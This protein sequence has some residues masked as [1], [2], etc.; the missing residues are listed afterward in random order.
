MS[1]I[2]KP[3]RHLSYKIRL[4]IET[5][6]K[7]SKTPSL[8]AK[9]LDLDLST[10]C[11]EIV[12]NSTFV[13]GDAFQDGHR[14]APQYCKRDRLTCIHRQRASSGNMFCPRDCQHFELKGCGRLN[15]KTSVCNGCPALQ[16]CQRDKIIYRAEEANATYEEEL[17]NSRKGQKLNI[18]FIS[19]E[20]LLYDRVVTQGHSLEFFL[21]H[22]PEFKVSESTLRRWIKKGIFKTVTHA[23]LR[24]TIKFSAKPEY[25]RP[26][27]KDKNILA[28]RTYQ[29]YQNFINENES[30]FVVQVDTVFGKRSDRKRLL[31]IHMPQINFMFGLLIENLSALRVKEAISRIRDFL[32]YELSKHY[33]SVLLTDNGFEMDL[34]PELEVDNETGEIVMNVFYCD[35]YRSSQKGSIERNHEFIR[36]IIEKG[37]SLD[38]YTQKD[39]TKLFSHINSYG[40][41]KFNM[42]SPMDLATRIFGSRFIEKLGLETIAPNA[43][44]LKPELLL[45]K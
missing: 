5:L 18:D 16:R 2:K 29:D 41:K 38:P 27:P 14:K 33:F 26:K 10:V 31:T 22:N 37:I 15:K 12:R 4:Q 9:E 21:K 11:R 25:V 8:I 39:F 34:L 17:V 23:L 44:I 35:P 43:I 6:L 19:L 1:T 24:N 36:Y 40:R 42:A 13:K 7:Q 20:K 30:V 45:K 32:G 28:G 3:G